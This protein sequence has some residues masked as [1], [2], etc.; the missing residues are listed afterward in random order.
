MVKVAG[1]SGDSREQPRALGRQM[2]PPNRRMAGPRPVWSMHRRLGQMLREPRMIGGQPG[3]LMLVGRQPM[4]GALI[5]E[6]FTGS[7]EVTVEDPEEG[8]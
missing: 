5:D 6:K 7:F 8:L 2:I 4:S 1:E 3:V